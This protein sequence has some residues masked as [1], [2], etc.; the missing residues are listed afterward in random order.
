MN[1]YEVFAR[2][3]VPRAGWLVELGPEDATRRTD[4]VGL[5]ILG[6]H[7]GRTFNILLDET[8]VA[9][10]I[11]QYDHQGELFSVEYPVP[12]ELTRV[13]E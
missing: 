1:E 3:S 11:S 10:Q 9:A 5:H 6:K 7:R 12:P 8:I 13:Q 4:D 2:R